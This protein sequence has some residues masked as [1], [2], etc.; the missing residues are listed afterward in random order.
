MSFHVTIVSW[1]MNG[2]SF[3]RSETGTERPVES[4]HY[5]VS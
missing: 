2:I 4:A 1:N 3:L 5:P